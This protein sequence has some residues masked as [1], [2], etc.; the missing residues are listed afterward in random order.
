LSTALN[1]RASLLLSSRCA[2][3]SP[4]QLIRGIGHWNRIMPWV[5]RKRLAARVLSTPAR[6]PVAC[7]RLLELHAGEETD[8]ERSGKRNNF[9][10]HAS[11]LSESAAPHEPQST[12]KS[13]MRAM[14]AA[15]TPVATE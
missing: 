15:P 8:D 10:R 1:S 5:Q 7:A 4:S 6:S 12:E 3:K 14:L 2:L 9:R 11:N 13:K